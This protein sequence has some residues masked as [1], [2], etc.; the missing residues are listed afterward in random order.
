MK[1]FAIKGS[2]F[3]LFILLSSFIIKK[4]KVTIYIIGDSTAANKE[5]KAFPE[6]GWGMKLQDFFKGNVS[7]DNRALNGR[8]TKSFLNEN[9]WQPI[10]NQLK[11]GDYVFIEFGHNDEKI[12]KPGTGTTLEEFKT[13]LVKYVNETRA[14]KACPVLLTPV[15]RRSFVNGVF[16]DSHGEYPAVTRR[17]ADSLHVP[18]IDMHKKTE[19]LIIG[20]GEEKAKSLFNYV[21]SGDVNYPKGKKD[22]THFNPYGAQKMAELVVEGIREQNIDLKKKLKNK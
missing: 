19:K 5:A 1:A 16:Q 4:D 12:N 21:D 17:V 15:M 13:N 6:T 8:S 2:F 7:V 9:R 11:A 10:I 14:K 22:D 3:S 18:L 20:L